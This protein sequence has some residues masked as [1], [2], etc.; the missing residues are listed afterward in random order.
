MRGAGRIRRARITAVLGIGGWAASTLGVASCGS[1]ELPANE[2]S[3][4]ERPA[5]DIPELELRSNG[6][7]RFTTCPPPGDLGQHWI[8]PLPPWTPPKVTA[9]AGAL[10]VDQDFIAR[11]A[12]RTPT[13][14]AVEATHRDFRSCY[15]QGLVRYPTQDGR[16]AIV[17]RIGGDGRVA[18]VE[19]YGACELAPESI[20]CMYGVAQRLRFPPPPS[21]SDTVTIPA[22]FTSRDGVRRTVPT[23]NDAYTAGAYVSLEAA[24]PAL[25]A[26]EDS[27]RR[28]GRPVESTGTFTMDIA[29][30]G[31]VAK[32]NVEPWR[33]DQALVL[34]AARALQGL[35]FATPVGGK[36]TVIARLNFNPRQGAR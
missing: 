26:C 34:C 31:R 7:D 28:E 8:P 4:I 29:S 12:D 36:G 3:R 5:A 22:T 11:T 24:R 35:Q 25:H 23:G 16:V 2:P 15:R 10:P 9:D 19:S 17:L 14:L 27:A 18:K 33:G 20:S 21:G 30:G 6:V 32:V 13:E 1:N